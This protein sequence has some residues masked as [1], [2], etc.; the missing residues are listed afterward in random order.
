[1]IR[2]R[3]ASGYQGILPSNPAQKMASS[4]T[5]PCP[6]RAKVDR[7]ADTVQLDAAVVSDLAP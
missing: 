5:L 1:L 7:A 3:R 6:G 2:L 4:S